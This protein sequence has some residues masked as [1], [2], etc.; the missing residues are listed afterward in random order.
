MTRRRP[1]DAR[2]LALAA[3]ILAL[4]GDGRKNPGLLSRWF[5]GEKHLPERDCAVGQWRSAGDS[6]RGGAECSERCRQA[7][8]ALDACLDA[9]EAEMGVPATQLTLLEAP[10]AGRRVG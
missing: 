10:A 2:Q 9:L 4:G 3:A 5:R 7:R 8:E 1:A 6:L